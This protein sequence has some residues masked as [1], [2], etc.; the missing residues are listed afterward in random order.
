MGIAQFYVLCVGESVCVQIVGVWGERRRKGSFLKREGAAYHN[1]GFSFPY[2]FILFS[3]YF[4]LF[5]I[6]LFLVFST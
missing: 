2:F 3:F 1:P 4:S 6:L 5:I